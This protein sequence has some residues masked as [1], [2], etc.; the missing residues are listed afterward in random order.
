VTPGEYR[1]FVHY[2]EEQIAY[3]F[4]KEIPVD[5]SYRKGMAS[6]GRWFKDKETGEVWR[7]IEPDFPFRGIFE[8]VKK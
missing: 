3:G 7:L 2:I 8:P 5:R 4:A 6:G 1:R